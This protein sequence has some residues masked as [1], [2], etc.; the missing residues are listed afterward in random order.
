VKSGRSGESNAGMDR[1]GDLYRPQL[2]LLVGVDGIP[3]SDFLS[4]PA[5]EWVD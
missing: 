5:S 1:F 3:L 2:S 4:K